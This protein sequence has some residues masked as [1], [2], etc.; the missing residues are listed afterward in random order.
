M[1]VHTL[2]ILQSHFPL[3]PPSDGCSAKWNKSLCWVSLHMLRLNM[4]DGFLLSVLTELFCLLSRTVKQQHESDPVGG[5]ENMWGKHIQLFQEQNPGLQDYL[6]SQFFHSYLPDLKIVLGCLGIWVV[7]YRLGLL[8][9]VGGNSSL[10]L[11]PLAV[12][13]VYSQVAT[14][15]QQPGCNP[16]AALCNCSSSQRTRKTQ[17]SPQELA[18][19]ESQVEPTLLKS[20]FRACSAP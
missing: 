16:S 12:F 5:G 20:F 3:N 11:F 8:G 9:V 15:Y 10:F 14:P 1:P 6:R 18:V 13:Q 7:W 2:S 17:L 4:I 19:N